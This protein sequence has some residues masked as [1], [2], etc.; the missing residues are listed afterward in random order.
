MAPAISCIGWLDRL[1]LFFILPG[2]R[3]QLAEVLLGIG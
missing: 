3:D 1:Y 2:F